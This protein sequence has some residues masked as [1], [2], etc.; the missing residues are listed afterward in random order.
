MKFTPT[1]LKERLFKIAIGLRIISGKLLNLR[2][3]LQ[4]NSAAGRGGIWRGCG[5]DGVEQ[6]EEEG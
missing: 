4:T 2:P 1:A 5:K 6:E 3:S